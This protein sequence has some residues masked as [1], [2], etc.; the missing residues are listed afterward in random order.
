LAII[1][2]HPWFGIGFGDAPSPDF[3]VGVSSI[4]LLIA[5]Q[6]G[7]VGL[8]LF[9]LFSSVVL[10]R[11]WHAFRATDDDL[12]LTAGAAFA[13]ALT[14]GLVDHYFFNMRFV[15]TV[16]LFWIV[17]G[18]VVALAGLMEAQAGTRG[19]LG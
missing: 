17:V 18:V 10:W 4:Y 5:E 6:T 19:D 12:L 3:G 11:A 14:V 1:R 2:A 16:G 15:H 7:L 8:A 13:A 9:G